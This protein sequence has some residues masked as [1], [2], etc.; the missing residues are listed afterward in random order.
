MKL[1]Q[2]SDLVH[3]PLQSKTTGEA[4]SRSAVLSE[5]LGTKEL[6]VHHEI[7]PPGRRSSASHWHAETD[8]FIYVIKGRPT[9]HEGDVSTR[10]SAG[11]CVCFHAGS[12]VG[13]HV[14]N[15]TSEEIEMLVVSRRLEKNDVVATE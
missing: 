15:D 7:L 5:A 2:R 13:H 3:S 14:S 10:A 8:E 1:V 6:F 11:D 9:V 4:F 12:G